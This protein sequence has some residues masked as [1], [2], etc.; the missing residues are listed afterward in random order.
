ME[1][2]D[3][4]TPGALLAEGRTAAIY[5]W[6]PGQVLKLYRPGFDQT[7]PEYEARIARAVFAAGVA[8]PQV[9]ELVHVNGQVGLEYERLDGNSLLE[10][11]L[12][13][14]W[15]AGWIGKQCAQIQVAMH[16]ISID[17]LP[18][19]RQRLADRIQANGPLSPDL[20]SRLLKALQNLPDD[21]RLC[22]G[23][24]HPGNLILSKHGPIAI[25]WVDAVSGQPTADVAR[26][27]ILVY[28]ASLPPGPLSLYI[29]MLRSWFYH[30]YLGEYARLAP[31]RLD[32]LQNWLPIMAAA[33]LAENIPSE[34]SVL[35]RLAGQVN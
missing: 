18:A 24:F 30:S 17:G 33:R 13:R 32:G 16:A 31:D 15:R 14:P 22:H 26:S 7:L 28:Y 1:N 4:P 29:R 19:Q 5:A 20:R 10:I 34:E 3:T 21:S 11:A 9:G 6:R 2:G 27:A 23:D 25:D 8:A 35:L 12:S